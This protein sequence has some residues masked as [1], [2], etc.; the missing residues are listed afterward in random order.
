VRLPIFRALR[1]ENPNSAVET[2]LIPSKL[3]DFLAALT[4]QG[5]QADDAAKRLADAFSGHQHSAQLIV[6]Q[7]TVP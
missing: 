5:K 4:R 1:W 6:V 7:H 2:D 3:P